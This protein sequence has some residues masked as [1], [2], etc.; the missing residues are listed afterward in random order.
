MVTV[1]LFVTKSLSSEPPRP[2]GLGRVMLGLATSLTQGCLMSHFNYKT[3]VMLMATMVG[4]RSSTT[5]L[6]VRRPFGSLR[7]AQVTE[8]SATRWILS[9]LLGKFPSE[10][11]T[12]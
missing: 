1:N 4:E 3:S 12:C 5:I 10:M 2:Y 9:F 6:R 8:V 7:E 11:V